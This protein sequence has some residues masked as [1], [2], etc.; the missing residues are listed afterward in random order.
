MLVSAYNDDDDGGDDT[1]NQGTL[2]TMIPLISL[3]KLNVIGENLKTWL[4]C[5]QANLQSFMWNASHLC[6]IALRHNYD[7]VLY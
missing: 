3:T 1:Q 5:V 7:Y 2:S 6:L 4:D